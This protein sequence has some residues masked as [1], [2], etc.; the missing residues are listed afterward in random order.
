MRDHVDT[1]MKAD[2]R[3]ALYSL[4]IMGCWITKGEKEDLGR[5]GS[6]H[7]QNVINIIVSWG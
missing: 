6:G 3:T 5:N 1:Y 7:S 4:I 2:I